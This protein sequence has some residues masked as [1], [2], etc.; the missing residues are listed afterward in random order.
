MSEEKM[1]IKWQFFIPIIFI[2]GIFLIK[3]ATAEPTNITLLQFND[4]Y[5]ITPVSGGKAGGLAR[6]ATLR[7][8]LLGQNPNTYTILAGD[9]FSPSA[10]GT[11]K[12]DGEPLAGQQMVAVL[13]AL[14]L[15]YATF[16]NHEFDLKE[17]QFLSRLKESKFK[18][19][20]S[21]VFDAAGQPFPGIPATEIINVKTG[22]NSLKIGLIGVTIDS[23]RANYVTYSDP[24][25]AAKKQVKALKEK[26]DII[27]AVTHLN[28]ALDQ[29]LAE[30]VP[31]IDVILGG[32]EHEN[33]QQWRGDDLT[34]LF[35]ADA[36]VRTVYIHNL[37]YNWPNKKLEVNSTI[38]PITAKIAEDPETNRV[39]REW[40]EKGFAAFRA[41]GF[42]PEEI[43]ANASM[44]LDGLEASV[45][46]MSTM[47][48]EVI[49]KGMLREVKNADLAIFNGG[50]IRIDDVIPPGPVTQYDVIRIL[51]FGGKVV[52]VELEGIL[53]KRVL[54][55]GL[56]NRGTGGFL[57]TANVSRGADGSGWLIGGKVLEENR[58]YRVAMTDFLLTGK[59][60][61]LGFLTAEQVGV[62]VLGEGRDIRFGLM[63][64][65]RKI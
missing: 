27:V 36:N 26:V 2:L 60:T 18:W 22:N 9:F 20:S 64:E 38:Q 3:P 30:V 28:L 46:N 1:K 15:D 34:P 11:A 65:L 25:E 43:V 21:N 41:G 44:P 55:Q 19:F 10:L 12:V 47:L 31:E 59:E 39:V 16:G 42:E 24:I 13:N 17:K 8:Q 35:K 4:V 63:D 52:G 23:N 5:E 61:G 50:S 53:L 48:T 6:V 51:P 14:G 32:H 58:R 40:V 57:H 45:R 33:I 62:K 37:R 49:A 29:K 7:K 56:A 54:D